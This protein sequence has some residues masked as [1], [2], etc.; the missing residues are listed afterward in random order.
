MTEELLP[1]IPVSHDGFRISVDRE[2]LHRALESSAK[3]ITFTAP[4][5]WHFG[6][7]RQL[8]PN[9]PQEQEN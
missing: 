1:E 9:E 3:E 2:A 4:P 7:D 6:P 8:H 5:G